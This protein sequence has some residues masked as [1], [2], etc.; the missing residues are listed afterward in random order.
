MF[1]AIL[2]FTV[3]GETEWTFTKYDNWEEV[4]ADSAALQGEYKD[5]SSLAIEAVSNTGRTL[6][7]SVEETEPLHNSETN[8]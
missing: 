2:V 1:K 5:A 8:S 7:V 6:E 4:K 3:D